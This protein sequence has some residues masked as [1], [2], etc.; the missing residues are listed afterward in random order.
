MITGVVNAE[1]E[2]TIRLT[3]LGPSGQQAVEAVIDTGFSGF[4]TLPFTIVASLGLPWLRREHGLLA[5][6][7]VYL[8]DVYRP[9]VILD[10]Q[11]RGIESVG[12]T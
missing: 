5:D 3:V 9:T 2:A 11:P 4:L 7:A 10:G 6:G 1:G 12:G 8:F